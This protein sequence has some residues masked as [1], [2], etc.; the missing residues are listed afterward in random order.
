MTIPQRWVTV[1]LAQ[2]KI[3]ELEED[4]ESHRKLS[5]SLIFDR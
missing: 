4:I 5:E 2:R 3:Q 1:A